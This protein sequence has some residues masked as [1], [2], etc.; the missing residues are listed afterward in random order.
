ME[1]LYIP[2]T[3]NT[4]E[5]NLSAEKCL[6]EIIGA[7]YSDNIYE[8]VYENVLNWIENQM[9]KIDCEINCIFKIS[10]LNSMTYKNLMQIL[11]KLA[12]YH[13][14]GKQITVTWY[15]EGDDEDNE[16]IAEDLSQIFDIPF[17]IKPISKTQS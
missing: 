11:I 10:I 4:P 12:D 14:A 5:V 1:N 13:K 8:E 16:E 17:T 9:P 3:K 15:F 2:K 7:S 6:F